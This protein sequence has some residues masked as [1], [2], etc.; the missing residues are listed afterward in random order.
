M[1]NTHYDYSQN[2]NR[3][4]KG[5]VIAASGYYIYQ[6]LIYTAYINISL[7][8]FNMIPFPPLDGSKVIGAVLPDGLYNDLIRKGSKAGMILLL[9]I[10]LCSR[11]GFSPIG[12]ASSAIFN[13]LYELIVL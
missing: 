6:L 2:S 9:A 1:E 8:V 12:A 4:S 13:Q 7:A 10:L 5:G 11:M 3:D